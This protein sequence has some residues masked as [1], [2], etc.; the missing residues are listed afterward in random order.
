[1]RKKLY[2]VERL[3][4]LALLAGLTLTGCAQS[5]KSQGE[6]AVICKAQGVQFWN[7]VKVGAEDGGKEMNYTIAYQATVNDTE[8]GEQIKMVENAV[9]RN[10]SAIVIAP[11][12]VSGLDTTLDKAV[13]AGIPV[14]TIDSDGDGRARPG[15]RSRQPCPDT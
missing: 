4:V 7:D 3:A 5:E 13:S 10:V 8:L 15:F 12:D 11:N 14:I 2:S 9:S 6:I 1:M